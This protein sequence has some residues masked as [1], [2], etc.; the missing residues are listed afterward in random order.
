M[1]ST[2]TL[3]LERSPHFDR[4]RLIVHRDV[5]KL[6]VS[7][8]SKVL[9]DGIEELETIRAETINRLNPHSNTPPRPPVLLIEKP[10]PHELL[11][12]IGQALGSCYDT[13]AIRTQPSHQDFI[14]APKE[15][16]KLKVY[17]VAI[18][19]RKNKEDSYKMGDRIGI[20]PDKDGSMR[21][22]ITNGPRYRKPEPEPELLVAI[23]YGIDFLEADLNYLKLFPEAHFPHWENSFSISSP[24][25]KRKH[26]LYSAVAIIF[27]PT[28]DLNIKQTIELI[29]KRT[30]N[31]GIYGRLLFEKDLQDYLDSGLRINRK[32]KRQL[33][34]SKRYI[35]LNCSQAPIAE[36][37]ER[38][39]SHLKRVL[40]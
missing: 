3:E 17:L 22:E 24:K 32:M 18:A 14:F 36:K 40:A 33:L 35:D 6:T 15:I 4:L 9:Q 38:Y 5:K 21:V 12:P 23:A 26:G 37:I 16:E 29:D 25:N 31:H 11:L 19:N 13:I 8:P 2:I 28:H 10:I 39:S 20:Y 27:K 7:N 30:A 1:T 34:G